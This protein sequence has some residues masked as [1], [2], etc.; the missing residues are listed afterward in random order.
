MGHEGHQPC[1]IRQKGHED[2]VRWPSFCHNLTDST[3]RG[4]VLGLSAV[5]S[6][7]V[8]QPLS[9]QKQGG[10]RTQQPVLPP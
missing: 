4:A 1:N 9:K 6:A 8:G 7:T 3:G 10:Q 5:L 2:E